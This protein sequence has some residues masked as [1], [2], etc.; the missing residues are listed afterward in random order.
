MSYEI[1]EVIG[2][3]DDRAEQRCDVMEMER[4]QLVRE[5]LGLSVAEGK[6]FCTAY[7]SW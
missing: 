2:V 7:Q 3:Q 5:T 4:Q 1:V 6:P